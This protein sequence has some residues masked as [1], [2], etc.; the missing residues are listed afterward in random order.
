MKNVSKFELGVIVAA[1][2][3]LALLFLDNDIALKVAVTSILGINSGFLMTSLI[4]S[5][6]RR[7]SKGPSIVRR[8]SGKSAVIV[9]KMT[10]DEYEAV[11]KELQMRVSDIKYTADLHETLSKS[12]LEQ[13]GYDHEATIDYYVRFIGNDVRQILGRLRRERAL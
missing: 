11:L 12:L 9:G 1:N 10:E 4:I 3:V 5:I 13:L 6:V 8:T 7:A 2:F